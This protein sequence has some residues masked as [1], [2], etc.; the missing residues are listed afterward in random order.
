MVVLCGSGTNFQ[1]QAET[2]PAFDVTVTETPFLGQFLQESR[3]VKTVQ[4]VDQICTRYFHTKEA[5][6]FMFLQSK[7]DEIRLYDG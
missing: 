4:D 2:R 5:M 6:R 3:G 7:S 1:H